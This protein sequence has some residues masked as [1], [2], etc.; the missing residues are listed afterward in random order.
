MKYCIASIQAAITAAGSKI[1][2]AQDAA[3]S[4]NI[5]AITSN[6][7][8]I[9]DY[10]MGLRKH[11]EIQVQ[12]PN[13]KNKLTELSEFSANLALLAGTDADFNESDIKGLLDIGSDGITTRDLE[14]TTVGC[15]L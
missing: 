9:A 3:R 2:A 12:R 10:A 7:G 1:S 8:A 13:Y 14:I 11:P 15:K 4:A 6:A 5:A